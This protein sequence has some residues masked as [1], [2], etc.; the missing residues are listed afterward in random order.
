[1]R[2]KT[3]Y[4]VLPRPFGWQFRKADKAHAGGRSALDRRLD[5]VRREE[6]KVIAS[7]CTAPDGRIEE[8]RSV[9]LNSYQTR[10]PRSS[11]MWPV[12]KVSE[13]V[14]SD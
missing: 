9:P 12:S 11:K 10:L 5:E 13:L 8:C 14:L 4:V 3:K 1:L 7:C 2:G 6:G